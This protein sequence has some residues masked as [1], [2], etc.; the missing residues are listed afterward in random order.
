M[1]GFEKRL[2]ELKG[3][4]LD[5]VTAQIG[6][7]VAGISDRLKI[8]LKPGFIWNTVQSNAFDSMLYSRASSY[9]LCMGCLPG[10]R[11][12]FL[13]D[14]CDI[15]DNPDQD[16]PLCLLTG[17]AGSGK[18]AVAHSIA[19]LY[20]KQKQLGSAYFFDKTDLANRNPNNL[21][22]TIARNLAYRDPQYKSALWEIVKD[23]LVLHTSTWPTEQVER[24]IIEPG[25]E[26]HPNKPLIIVIDG[27]DES[28][29]RASREGLLKIISAKIAENALPTHLRFLITTRAEND[30]IR[31]LPHDHQVARISMDDVPKETI[32]KDIERFIQH[33][34][35]EYFD[36]KSSLDNEHCQTLVRHSEQLFLWASSACDTI[37]GHRGSAGVSPS[38]RLNRILGA[39]DTDYVHSLD[40]L[41]HSVLGQLF[42]TEADQE[43]FQTVMATVLSVKEPLTLASLCAL[44][45]D[46][47]TPYIMKSLASLVSGVL[48]EDRP[49]RLLHT[50]F[51]DF[52]LDEARSGVFYVYHTSNEL[53]STSVIV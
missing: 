42:T 17:V 43:L 15:L 14:I 53:S 12:S 25:K 39:S 24:F 40:N 6:V 27:L 29:D 47:E 3:T 45:R 51:R 22:S 52:L 41:Y 50:S 10:T 30:I 23:S 16:A 28:G 11:Q 49:I 20:A 21:F 8:I 35:D 2:Q 48:D 33:S 31:S 13:R 4:L 44:N 19:Q 5:G 37:K 18:S 7:T 32:E 26:L 34:L 46:R 38:L 9:N 36:F 1:A